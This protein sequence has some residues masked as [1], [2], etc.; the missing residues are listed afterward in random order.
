MTSKEKKKSD[1]FKIEKEKLE[2]TEIL[3][4]NSL[5][6]IYINELLDISKGLSSHSEILLKADFHGSIIK[7]TRSKNPSYVDIEG[8]VLQETENSFKILTKENLI[9]SNFITLNF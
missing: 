5:W 9:K 7:C 2:Y 6:N 3:K 1:I 8:I 4:M